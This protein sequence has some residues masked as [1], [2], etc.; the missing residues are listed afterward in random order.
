MSW[1]QQVYLRLRAAPDGLCLG[2]LF[3][4]VKEQIPLHYAMR[5]ASRLY[6]TDKV[7]GDKAQWL[8][9]TNVVSLLGVE[10]NS[11]PRAGYAYI[12]HV[13]LR[14]VPGRTCDTCGGP[15]Q[16]ELLCQTQCCLIR[17]KPHPHRRN[18]KRRYRS[19]RHPS[20]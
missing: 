20:H 9:F 15:D 2:P 17:A 16:S 19:S 18:L 3:N 7:S 14:A 11:S 10:R 13:R 6:G 8:Y 4:E 1:R 5:Y 12:D